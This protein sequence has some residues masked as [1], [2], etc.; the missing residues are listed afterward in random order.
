MF[1]PEFLLGL[2]VLG[3]T[4]AGALALSAMTGIGPTWTLISVAV[5][6]FALFVLWDRRLSRRGTTPKADPIHVAWENRLSD[7]DF[8][9]E[10]EQTLEDLKSRGLT[11]QTALGQTFVFATEHEGSDGD[12]WFEGHFV[13]DGDWIV[14]RATEPV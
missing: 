11:P 10:G 12:I 3:L 5:L 4:F 1:N 14:I 6:V 7:T 2:L 13:R 9:V 8:A